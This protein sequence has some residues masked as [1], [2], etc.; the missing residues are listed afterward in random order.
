MMSSKSPQ[1]D[2]ALTKMACFCPFFRL[3]MSSGSEA[4]ANDEGAN[5][6]DMEYSDD[7]RD[8]SDIP[9]GREAKD[10][11]DGENVASER[12]RGE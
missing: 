10:E 6:P 8:E 12:G 7:S 5:N 9:P 1:T 3:E 11:F 2:I 4:I